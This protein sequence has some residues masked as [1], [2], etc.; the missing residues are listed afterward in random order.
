MCTAVRWRPHPSAFKNV[1]L[2]STQNKPRSDRRVPHQR[3]SQAP[4]QP[5]SVLQGT[6][7]QLPRNEE[8][9]PKEQQP[10]RWSLRERVPIS[11][12][13]R[14]R[15][16]IRKKETQ[17]QQGSMPKSFGH[18][19]ILPDGHPKTV[20]AHRILQTLIPQSTLTYGWNAR[21]VEK[22]TPGAVADLNGHIWIKS[23]TW[24]I[25]N[26]DSLAFLISHEMGHR[27][28]RH[29]HEKLTTTMVL[30]PIAVALCCVIG[31]LQIA[32]GSLF[33]IWW[34]GRYQSRKHE[35]EADYMGLMIMAKSRFDPRSA[36]KYLK[37]RWS[38]ARGGIYTP[39]FLNTHPSFAARIAKLEKWLPEALREREA[40]M[41]AT[42][43][44][45]RTPGR[46]ILAAQKQ[47]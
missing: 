24:N 29:L 16:L 2:K 18:A 19:K 34:Y 17:T 31:N 30:G 40:A 23:G 39:W 21:V 12:R 20:K 28:A 36:V 5:Q 46:T 44:L 25:T 37:D 1:A 38:A 8:T 13:R 26:D 7:R 15:V 6:P 35:H 32:I 3:H 10:A 41:K 45:A 42:Q 11:G 43:S 47:K 22:P 14:F 4:S 33:G 9:R 27:V